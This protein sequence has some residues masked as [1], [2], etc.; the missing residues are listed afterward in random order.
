M[1]DLDIHVN[2]NGLKYFKTR[3]NKSTTINIIIKD[4]EILRN[5]ILNLYGNKKDFLYE[6]LLSFFWKIE[7]VIKVE[8]YPEYFYLWAINTEL[9]VIVLWQPSFCKHYYLGLISHELSH[10]L[11]KD[12]NLNRFIEEVICFSIEKSIIYE[13]D[14]V[15]TKD[16]IYYENS[17]F[18]HNKAL[19][20]TH[21]YYNKFLE[22][23][24]T[25]F[26]IFLDNEVP[27]EFKEIK[28][29]NSLINYLKENG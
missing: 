22:M 23:N 2:I 10:L 17:D 25:D 6:K 12:Y 11:L 20:F 18:F 4:A 5:S 8:I 15:D 14:W 7:Q 29:A 9:R 13:F 24:L 27:P 16:F 28:I 1:L 3:L 26:M 21:K 19:Y